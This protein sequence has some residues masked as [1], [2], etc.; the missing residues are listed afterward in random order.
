MEE[1]VIFLP[2]G[3]ALA[4]GLGVFQSIQIAVLRGV[5]P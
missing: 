2:L 4:A 5:V 1:G 3:A